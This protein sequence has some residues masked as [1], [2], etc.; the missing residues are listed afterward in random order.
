MTSSKKIQCK[1]THPVFHSSLWKYVT[2]SSP[3][4]KEIMLI[5]YLCSAY[6]KQQ[7]FLLYIPIK[8][9]NHTKG[10]SSNSRIYF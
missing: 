2:N 6:I 9:L 1:Y 4:N 7:H 8:I 5:V 10:D 3:A